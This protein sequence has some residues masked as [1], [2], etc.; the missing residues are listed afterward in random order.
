MLKNIKTIQRK[1]VDEEF[2]ATLFIK[3][4]FYPNFLM[5]V[6]PLILIAN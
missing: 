3:G 4:K 2:Y 5:L 1:Y 6:K